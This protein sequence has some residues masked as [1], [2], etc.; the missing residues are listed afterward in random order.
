MTVGCLTGFQA[1][2]A[3]EEWPGIGPELLRAEWATEPGEDR[4]EPWS[5]ELRREKDKVT[6]QE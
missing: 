5:R 1:G 6:E 3:G 4:R 2:N